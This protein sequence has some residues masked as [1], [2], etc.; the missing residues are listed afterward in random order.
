MN[1]L[2]VS[3]CFLV[4]IE[5]SGEIGQGRRTAGLERERGAGDGESHLVGTRLVVNPCHRHKPLRRDAQCFGGLGHEL[6]KE[7]GNV[8]RQDAVE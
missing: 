6:K 1:A 2:G 5:L 7:S 3:D 4:E 8:R